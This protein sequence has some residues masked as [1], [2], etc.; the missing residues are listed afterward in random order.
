MVRRRQG[1]TLVGVAALRRRGGRCG[2]EGRGA[3]TPPG[4]FMRRRGPPGTASPRRSSRDGALETVKAYLARIN[5]GDAAGL[6]EISAP[7]LRFVDALGKEYP[8]GREGWEAYFSDFPDYR[9]EVTTIQSD[10]TMVAIF[11][12]ASGSFRGYGTGVPGAAW[13]VPAAWRA[14]VRAGKLVEWQVYCDVEP[15][16]RS[17]GR[18][19]FSEAGPAPGPRGGAR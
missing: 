4:T 9:I 14:I 17:A 7:D 5:A 11:G 19:R 15:M 2:T 6:A 10:G 18:G 13:R 16:L 8:L 1:G 3:H 12:T